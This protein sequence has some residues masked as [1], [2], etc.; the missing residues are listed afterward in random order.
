MYKLTPEHKSDW[1]KSEFVVAWDF[2]Y[3]D[4]QTETGCFF[5]PMDF[6][7]VIRQIW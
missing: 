6:S 5:F 7:E 1:V 2:V 3:W 4:V